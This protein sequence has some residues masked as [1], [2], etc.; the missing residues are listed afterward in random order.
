M[1]TGAFAA[2]AFAFAAA[3]ARAG[4]PC[5]PPLVTC[6]PPESGLE[7]AGAEPDEV[8]RAARARFPMVLAE[9]GTPSGLPRPRHRFVWENLTV[10]RANPLGALNVFQ[11]AYRLQLWDS[12]ERLFAD[13]FLTVG[14][15]VRIAPAFGHVGIRA[16]VQPLAV[17]NLFVQ[18]DFVGAFG[19]SDFLQRFARAD[20]AHDDATL[21]DLRS[22]NETGTGYA[23]SFGARLQA[24]V[25]NIAARDQLSAFRQGMSLGDAPVLY[26][27]PTFD[28]LQDNGG[29]VVTNDADLVYVTDFGLK[30]AL[31]HT[32]TRAFHGVETRG[33]DG[34]PSESTHRLGPA[35]AYTMFAAP[36]GEDFTE[37]TAALVTQWWLVHPY[38]TGQEQHAALPYVL[39]VLLQR[40][41]FL[42]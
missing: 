30:L 3:P 16:E 32:F 19:G 4:E 22:E 41:D 10:L 34:E 20:A 11:A 35:V 23:V 27:H 6:E 9:L 5:P 36:P 42:P 39:L 14:P 40:G 24:Q 28:V 37:V 15:Q 25:W 1:R 38:R 18:G 7:T 8:R 33:A 2:V 12:P 29:F 17:L 13:T 21:K 31:R 26:Y